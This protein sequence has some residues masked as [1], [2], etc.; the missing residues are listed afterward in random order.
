MAGLLC[1][2]GGCLLWH[3]ASVSALDCNL[4][5]YEHQG[6]CCSR[7]RPGY[8][9]QSDC[10]AERESVCAACESKHFQPGWTKERHCSPHRYCDPNAKLVLRLPGDAQSDTKC[11]CELGTFCSSHECQTCLPISAC[12]PGHGVAHI[13]NISS[14]TVCEPC[15]HGYFSSNSSASEP[16][17]RWTSCEAQGLLV[18]ANGTSRV[19]VLCEPRRSRSPALVLIPVVVA[20]TCL[21]GLGLLLCRKGCRPWVQKQAVELPEPVEIVLLPPAAKEVCEE[22]DERQDFP[23]QETLMGRQPVAQ[24]DGK[25]SRISE[26]ER[27]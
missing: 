19:D 14:D 16:C 21:V 22:H 12:Q 11:E 6:T 10:T 5:Q 20:T 2:L 17:R 9:L 8:K 15:A 1:L 3:W 18:K 23:V 13:A 26:Q 27:L 25:E 4:Q 7:C 24:E